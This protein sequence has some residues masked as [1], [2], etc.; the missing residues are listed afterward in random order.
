MNYQRSDEYIHNR[1][2]CNH[3]HF[4]VKDN[5]R[6]LIAPCLHILCSDCCQDRNYCTICK[7]QSYFAELTEDIK[8][9]L[10]RNVNEVFEGPISI[11]KFQ[12][13]NSSSIILK[14]NKKVIEYK[15]ALKE[16]KELIEILQKNKRPSLP[17]K[18]NRFNHKSINNKNAR[19]L[20]FD[21]S[22]YQSTK[23]R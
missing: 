11:L 3:C 5:F 4:T 23:K 22:L 20:Q 2:F 19:T 10:S 17:S 18:N 14:L 13:R 12:L 21:F 8:E 9:K 1:I 15:K 6:F 16:A 7:K